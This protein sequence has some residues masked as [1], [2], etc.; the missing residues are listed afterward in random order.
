MKGG[1]LRTI[2]TPVLLARPSA[3]S[4]VCDAKEFC[5]RA[6]G[7]VDTREPFTWRR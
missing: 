7:A 6:G 5:A 2:L 4:V 3:L 1:Y